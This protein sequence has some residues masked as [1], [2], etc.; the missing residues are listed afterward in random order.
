[1]DDGYKDP[2]KSTFD[3]RWN[4]CRELKSAGKGSVGTGN[5]IALLM[6]YTLSAWWGDKWKKKPSGA[7]DPKFGDV[8]AASEYTTIPVS[9]VYKAMKRLEHARWVDIAEIEVGVLQ[10]TVLLDDRARKERALRRSEVLK[11]RNKFSNRESY[12]QI[13]NPSLKLRIVT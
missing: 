10:V 5:D 12:S 2:I 9:T 13:E 7:V 3:A 6:Y 8:E 4:L 1:M 11:L